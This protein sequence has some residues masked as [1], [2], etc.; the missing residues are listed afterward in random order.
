[1]LET[2]IIN[3]FGDTAQQIVLPNWRSEYRQYLAE[4]VS[5]N[6]ESLA[7]IHDANMRELVLGMV[8]EFNEGK[9]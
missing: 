5:A 2:V 7:E 3:V 8:R 1:M 4:R 9:K 6:P